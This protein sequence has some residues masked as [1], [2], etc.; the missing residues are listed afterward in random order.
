MKLW[1]AYGTFCAPCCCRAPCVCDSCAFCACLP[2]Q[3]LCFLYGFSAEPRLPETPQRSSRLLL[4]FQRRP[5]LTS[6]LTARRICEVSPNYCP[7]A[8]EQRPSCK[9]QER[10]TFTAHELAWSA[11]ARSLKLLEVR[12]LFQRDLMIELARPC[13]GTAFLLSGA[14]AMKDGALLPPSAHRGL[15]YD[16]DIPDVR[17]C[18]FRRHCSRDTASIRLNGCYCGPTSA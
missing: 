10:W 18:A 14:H 2:F 9:V 12:R 8:F 15:P 6:S 16:Q 17:Q 7:E 11:K 5:L 13:E 1:P 4:L 3:L